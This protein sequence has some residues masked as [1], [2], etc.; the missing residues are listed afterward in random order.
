M[1]FLPKM[2]RSAKLSGYWY[3][4]TYFVKLHICVYLRTKFQVSSKIL[5]TLR[6]GRGW[7]GGGRGNCL[8]PPPPDLKTNSQ[9][10]YPD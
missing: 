4:K 5:T 6:Q 1:L 7:W 2:V 8:L 3:Q 10:T 9:K